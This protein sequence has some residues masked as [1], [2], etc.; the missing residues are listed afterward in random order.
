MPNILADRN[1]LER[2]VISHRILFKKVSIML[3]GRFPKLKGS[4]CN[5]PIDLA[6]IT[7]VLPHGTDSNGLVVVKLK[8]K[9][10]YHGHVYFEAVCPETVYHALLYLR[11]SNA[12]Y[13]DIE[14]VSDN[15]P[16]DLLSYQ[17]KMKMI[18][19]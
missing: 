15:I 8:R 7:N 1:R 12:L 3:K 9:L 14:I 5:I 11:Q 16:S 17:R 13:S 6:D 4:I 2:A 19:H 10:N 18:K